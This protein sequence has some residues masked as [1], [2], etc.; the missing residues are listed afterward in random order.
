MTSILN[1]KEIPGWHKP[2]TGVN[3]PCVEEERKKK[4]KE[5]KIPVEHVKVDINSTVDNSFRKVMLYITDYGH[6]MAKSLILYS[7][8]ILKA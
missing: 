5:K 8:N 6:L 4:S 3:N 2:E 7:P 1:Q